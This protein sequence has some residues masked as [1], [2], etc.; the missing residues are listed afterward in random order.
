M[1]SN[2]QYKND[3][4]LFEYD[5]FFSLPV[6]FISPKEDNQRSSVYDDLIEEEISSLLEVKN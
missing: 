4:M 6:D 3:T 5:D 1:T 2:S